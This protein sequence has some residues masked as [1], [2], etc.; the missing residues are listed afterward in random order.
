[1]RR[2]LIVAALGAALALGTAPGASAQV[3]YDPYGGMAGYAGTGFG[4]G[5][6]YPAFGYD[7]YGGLAG[8]GATGFG[9]GGYPGVGYTGAAPLALPGPLA[10]PGPQPYGPYGSGG[11]GGYPGYGGTPY[12]TWP[13]YAA[14]VLTGVYNPTGFPTFGLFPYL[15]QTQQVANSSPYYSYNPYAIFFGCSAT[16]TGSSYYVCR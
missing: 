10:I 3:G 1:M 14:P 16:Y 13:G 7:P 11:Y 9:L 6:G 15:A 2:L 4:A 8:Y 5:A 12:G